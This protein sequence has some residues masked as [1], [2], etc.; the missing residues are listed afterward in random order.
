MER[1]RQIIPKFNFSKR[2]R[3]T[4][5]LCYQIVM[6]KGSKAKQR[7]TKHYKELIKISDEVFHMA[8]RCF[9][10]LEKH[11]MEELDSLYEELDHYLNLAA[12]AIDQCERRILKGEKVPASEKIVS[13]FEDH[14]DTSRGGKASRPLSLATKC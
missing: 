10:E 4:R 6:A 8:A 9:T 12:T 14:T 11:P 7:R 5:K 1:C 2:T 13:I 3:K